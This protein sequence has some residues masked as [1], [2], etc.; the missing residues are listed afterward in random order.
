[1]WYLC[2]ELDDTARLLDLALGLGGEVAGAD[3]ERDLRN[4]TLSEHLGVAEIEQVEDRS[5]VGLL[6]GEVLLA[7]LSWHEGPEL[8]EVDNGLPEVVG[9]KQSAPNQRRL[10]KT[11]TLSV[12]V[13]HAHFTEVTWMVLVHVGPVVML[14]T[15]ETTTTGVLSCPTFSFST[16]S[17]RH[18]TYGACQRDRDRH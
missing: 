7:L 8:I 15:S 6:V 17:R 5:G 4:A 13:P 16:Y 10:L 2:D 9:W 11:H 14:A 1:M 12:E 18:C 3:D